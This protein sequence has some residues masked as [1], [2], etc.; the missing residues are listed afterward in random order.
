MGDMIT[1]AHPTCKAPDTSD[2]DTLAQNEDAMFTSKKYRWSPA[3]AGLLKK[4]KPV[5]LFRPHPYA[6]ITI[7]TTVGYFF[8]MA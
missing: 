4:R 6:P 3:L 8:M 1:I 5:N 2:H 7:C